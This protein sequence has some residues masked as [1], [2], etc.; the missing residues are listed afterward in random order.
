V[1]ARAAR[2]GLLRAQAESQSNR[3]AAA[4]AA[5]MAVPR[6]E[7]PWMDAL[8]AGKDVSWRIDGQARAPTSSWLYALAEQTQGRWRTASGMPPAPGDNEVQWW[9]NGVLQ[10]R[11]WLGAQRVLWCSAQGACE[12]A[13]LDL[14][15]TTALRKGLTR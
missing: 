9:R 12:E 11:L 2:S 14:D 8:A 6:P 3:Q 15:V 5:I 4:P 10:G 13:P 7:G 1:Q